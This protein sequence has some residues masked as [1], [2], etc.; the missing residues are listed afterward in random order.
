MDLSAA[1]NLLEEQL[2]LRLERLVGKE[3][4]VESVQF[5]ARVEDGALQVT[6]VAECR[7]EIG[8]EVPSSVPIP[9]GNNSGA[10]E[11]P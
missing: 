4:T 6:A 1:Q 2:T 3:G 10:Q 8:R 7:E 11:A 9:G 5:T